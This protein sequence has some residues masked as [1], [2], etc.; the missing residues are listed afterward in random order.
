MCVRVAG[1]GYG[2]AK[3]SSGSSSRAAGG[4][5]RAACGERPRDGAA[6]CTAPSL[7]QELGKNFKT[8]G[9]GWAWEAL[10]SVGHGTKTT[11]SAVR[12]AG[13]PIVCASNGGAPRTWRGAASRPTDVARACAALLA[14]SSNGMHA[15]S[16]PPSVSSKKLASHLSI[17]FVRPPAA[18]YVD[19][20]VCPSTP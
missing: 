6:R 1:A 5:S 15:C 16:L 12:W 14:V 9:V 2:Q 10:R 4:S 19:L 13:R 20:C 7:P 11:F 3:H 8:L 18:A 17:A